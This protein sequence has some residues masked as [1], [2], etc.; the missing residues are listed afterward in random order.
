MHEE[1]CYLFALEIEQLEVGKN[2]D[3]LPAHC[4][5]VHRFYSLLGPEEL[6]ERAQGI[7]DKYQGVTFTIGDLVELGP[8]K[9]KAFTIANKEQLI[10]LHNEL[11]NLLNELKTVYTE[12]EWVGDGYIPHI[13]VREGTP[14]TPGQPYTA[15]VFCIIE[16]KIPDLPHKRVV[17]AKRSLV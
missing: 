17:R 13:S 3:T 7:F 11:Y 15:K 1:R 8:K 4:T 14:L 2:Y 10:A 9:T 12:K 16:V 5:L 6:M